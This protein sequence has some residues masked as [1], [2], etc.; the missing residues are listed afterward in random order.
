ME[1]KR[2]VTK[3]GIMGLCCG[4]GTQWGFVDGKGRWFFEDTMTLGWDNGGYKGWDGGVPKRGFW[5]LAN[6]AWARGGVFDSAVALFGRE[7]L[8]G[9]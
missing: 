4:E 8:I 5:G 3:R 7:V 6:E 1:C 2:G 9:E